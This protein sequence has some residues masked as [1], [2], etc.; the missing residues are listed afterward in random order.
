M[1]KTTSLQRLKRSLKVDENKL[2][3]YLA[4]YYENQPLDPEGEEMLEKYRKA[5][6]L[7]SLGR[8]DQMV[9]SHL[10]KEYKIQER[11]ARYIIAE[12]TTLYGA[13]QTADKQGK[14]IASAN[15]Y[16][17]LSNLA[18]QQGDYESAARAWERAD[19]LEGLHDNETA[20]WDPS[21]FERAAK[22]VFINNVNVLKQSKRMAEDE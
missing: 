19:R 2:D 8:T 4:Y 12:S 10:M 17:L 15:Y 11:Q 16:R 9:I 3:K 7:M 5:W 14:K 21:D 22:I 20:G 6:T 13:V 1:G 18:M